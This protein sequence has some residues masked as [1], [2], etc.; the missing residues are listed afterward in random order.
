M[1]PLGRKVN[2]AKLSY[3]IRFCCVL[4]RKKR[5]NG[6]QRNRTAEQNTGETLVPSDALRKP[7]I[8]LRSSY[9]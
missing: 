1:T 9:S 7:I 5:V 6:S 2:L 8:P 3:A 4:G